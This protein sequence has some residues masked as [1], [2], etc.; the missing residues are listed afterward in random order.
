M[1]AMGAGTQRRHFAGRPPS[2]WLRSRTRPERIR[3]SGGR[4]DLRPRQGAP[5]VIIGPR[6]ADEGRVFRTKLTRVRAAGFA[7]PP[8]RAR[9]HGN[10]S[11]PINKRGG[12]GG[13]ISLSGALRKLVLFFSPKSCDILAWAG[14]G[15]SLY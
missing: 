14:P 6:R 3:R 7:D 2:K 13:E 11:I 8:D 10:G 12:P 4:R 9:H 1:A 5:R 15:P